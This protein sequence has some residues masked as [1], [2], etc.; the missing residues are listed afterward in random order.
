M[1]DWAAKCPFQKTGN[2][3]TRLKVKLRRTFRSGK[4]TLSQ[5]TISIKFRAVDDG[6]AETQE[7]LEKNGRKAE[8]L[9]PIVEAA[10]GLQVDC[11]RGDTSQDLSFDLILSKGTVSDQ[12]GTWTLPR[13]WSEVVVG[14]SQGFF[15]KW[16]NVT[17]Q[18][19]QVPDCVVVF[20]TSHAPHRGW[21]MILMLKQIVCQQR[22]QGC[23]C[24]P[25]LSCVRLVSCF[26]WHLVMI[27]CV[28]GKTQQFWILLPILAI[29]GM[30]EVDFRVG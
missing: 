9:T 19:Q 6:F 24:C 25:A 2:P 21:S 14:T 8:F 1:F 22:I 3:L 23:R 13:C 12:N 4:Q 17:T 26:W 11:K 29:H 18:L 28:T 7:T 27:D 30:G 15:R 16:V 10:F 20:V 5:T